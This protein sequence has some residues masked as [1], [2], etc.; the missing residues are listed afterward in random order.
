MAEALTPDDLLSH[1]EA[2]QRK[3][4]TRRKRWARHIGAPYAHDT[5]K[6]DPGVLDLAAEDE[7]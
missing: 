2:L 4:A 1:A 7:G 3:Y 5:E 6:P